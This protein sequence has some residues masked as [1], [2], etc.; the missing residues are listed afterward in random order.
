MLTFTKSGRQANTWV[1]AVSLFWGFLFGVRIST[2]I[3]I[4][5]RTESWWW[6][7]N[8]K[9]MLE[10]YTEYTEGTYNPVWEEGW[11]LKFPL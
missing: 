2:Q 1:S 5:L 10:I 6:F 4:V 9:A 11:V 7:K 8:V 3:N